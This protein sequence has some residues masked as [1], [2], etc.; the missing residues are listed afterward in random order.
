MPSEV[1]LLT[2]EIEAPHLAQILNHFAPELPIVGVHDKSSLCAHF[3]TPKAGRRLV[4]L[5]TDIVVP[6][7]VLGTLD[8][9]AY[10]FHPGPPEYPG[11]YVSG[12]A[13][14]EGAKTFGVTMHE[15]AACVDSGSIVAVERFDIPENAKFM[16]LEIMAYKALISLFSDVAAHLA[17]NDAPLPPSGDAWVGPQRTKAQR[18]RLKQIEADM[19]EAEIERRYRAFG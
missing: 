6:A 7:S 17:T 10:N 5:C 3:A 9:A 8:M 13:I 19:S 14:Y 12:F 4:A 15:M 2:G 1:V 18:A 11:S 16:D